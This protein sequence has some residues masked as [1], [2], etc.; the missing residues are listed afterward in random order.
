MR[1]IGS[2]NYGD[3]NLRHREQF[4]QAPQDSD[5]RIF[6]RRFI[7]AA[8]HDRGKMQTWH[9]ANHRGMKR[10]ARETEPYEADLNH[11]CFTLRIGK[12]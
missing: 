2:G 10:A 3:A 4:V 6:F 12:G 7:A 11:E 5:I 1:L 8:L 9:R